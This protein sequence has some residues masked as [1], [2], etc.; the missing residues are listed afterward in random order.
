MKSQTKN[1]PIVPVSAREEFVPA[2]PIEVVGV[3]EKTQAQKIWDVISNLRL[4]MFSLNNQFVHGYYK[5]LFVEPTRLYLVAITK[6]SAALPA[7]EVALSPKYQ[8][9]QAERFVIVSLAP[10]L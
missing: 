10:V 6:A 8:V 9:E 1:K 7:L 4:D 3:K 2:A 5:P